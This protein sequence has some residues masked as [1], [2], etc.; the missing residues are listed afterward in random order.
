MNATLPTVSVIIPNF[1]NAP[2]LPE[3][4]ESVLTQ[5]YPRLEVVVCDDC[6]DDASWEILERFAAAHPNLQLLRNGVNLGVSRTRHRAIE[7]A[8]GTYIATLDGDDRYCSDTKIATEVALILEHLDKGADVAAYSDVVHI[9]AS[10]TPLQAGPDVPLLEGDLFE[11]I[12]TRSCKIPRD[13]LVAKA[14]Y[15][16]AGGFDPERN[17]YEDWDF[18]IRLAKRCHFYCTGQAGVA[19][20]LKD[21]G[22]S[23][24]APMR[25]LQALSEVFEKNLPLVGDADRRTRLRERFEAGAMNPNTLFS[26]HFNRFYDAV[27]AFRTSGL[28][29]VVYGAGKVGRTVCALMPD[30]VA[31][32]VDMSSD[33]KGTPIDPGKVYSPE[34]LP[35]MDYDRILVAVLGRE[36]SVAAYL[37]ETLGIPPESIVTFRL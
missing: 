18:K 22:L 9:D 7:A 4:L 33:L 17:L 26:I 25:S 13:F 10:G 3:C 32:Q 36:A 8:T 35:E 6:S 16:E 5:S 27:E 15:F 31:G 14:R 2:Y 20:R 34:M 1:N 24:V 28:K 12:L 37:N 11:A 21:S 23:H 19:Y 30:A 29:Y